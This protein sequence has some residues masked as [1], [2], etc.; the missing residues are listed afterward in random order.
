MAQSQV[1]TA[2]QKQDWID[3]EMAKLNPIAQQR[4]MKELQEKGVIDAIQTQRGEES[5]DRQ[6]T[7][8]LAKPGVPEFQSYEDILKG[9]DTKGAAGVTRAYESYLKADKP[10]TEA[11]QDAIGNWSYLDES[12][13]YEPERR[14]ISVEEAQKMNERAE[15]VREQTKRHHK[16]YTKAKKARDK[17]MKKGEKGPS[18]YEASAQKEF[19]RIV[20]AR[21][22]GT[23]KEEPFADFDGPPGT[24][25]TD[26]PVKPSRPSYVD[27][28]QPTQA[29]NVATKDSPSF[30][31]NEQT[32]ARLK[33]LKGKLYPEGAPEANQTSDVIAANKPAPV[34]AKTDKVVT[35]TDKPVVAK[36]DKVVTK[37]DT[38]KTDTTKTPPATKV[39]KAGGTSPK[40]TITAIKEGAK[41]TY[42]QFVKQWKTT[43][44]EQDAKKNEGKK[45]PKDKPPSRAKK[46]LKKVAKS[47]FIQRLKEKQRKAQAEKD[48]KTQE[49]KKKNKKK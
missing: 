27:R 1:W 11:T 31:N 41:K 36:T 2:K 6:V 13:G 10:Y 37:T 40:K 4:F 42:K 33:A 14:M 16:E 25:S 18:G 26:S 32:I 29:W 3:K 20:Q 19:A 23:Y 38:T 28:S 44:A 49:R 8:H 45:P 5:Q 7:E 30:R 35:K 47:S 34:V 9:M 17:G 48:R 43:K 46:D 12:P 15:M 22:A 21:D 39:A 24:T